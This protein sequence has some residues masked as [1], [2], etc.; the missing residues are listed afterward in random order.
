MTSDS[1]NI[2]VSSIVAPRLRQKLP[3]ISF[4]DGYEAVAAVCRTASVGSLITEVSIAIMRL[5]VFVAVS[6]AV[7][8]SFGIDITVARTELNAGEQLNSS[9]VSYIYGVCYDLKYKYS[10]LLITSYAYMSSTGLQC[11]FLGKTKE[12]F[13]VSDM[14]AECMDKFFANSL[15]INDENDLLQI[16]SFFL[17][18]N[19]NS[20]EEA[21]QIL[22]I[23]NDLNGQNTSH[24][25]QLNSSAECISIETNALREYNI[26]NCPQVPLQKYL[27]H[28]V[29][30]VDEKGLNYCI[31]PV[32][33]S[34]VFSTDVGEED[35][36]KVTTGQVTYEEA[37]NHCIKK[38]G[39]RLID[40][41]SAAK[42]FLLHDILFYPFM[43]EPK[44]VLNSYQM[45][46]FLIRSK[47]KFD[48]RMRM[49]KDAL[50]EKYMFQR[51]EYDGYISDE[52]FLLKRLDELRI[53]TIMAENCSRYSAFICEAS[54]PN[55]PPQK[56]DVSRNKFETFNEAETFC[57]REFKGH[58]LSVSSK[59][60]AELL[61][62]ILFDDMKSRSS[63]SSGRLLGIRSLYG[64]LPKHTDKTDTN[65]VITT[66]YGD[67]HSVDA[68]GKCFIFV[69]LYDQQRDTI[70]RYNCDR[71]RPIKNLACKVL[72]ESD[73]LD[74]EA[75]LVDDI[76]G[77]RKR[78]S[79]QVRICIVHNDYVSIKV[80]AFFEFA[81]CSI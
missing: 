15:S 51:P 10:D 50:R 38:F 80:K 60:E 71:T 20:S 21:S 9:S 76:G 79:L 22:M 41:N 18:H 1:I 57:R 46:S 61:Y 55:G 12:E 52:C 2:C 29:M 72:Q 56:Q 16:E 77:R 27:V 3:R 63:G 8:F 26:R 64:E 24:I 67:K 66:A 54:V 78:E 13:E 19:Y 36:V 5:L 53:D 74:A 70:L 4:A 30:A 62:E 81:I 68:F 33:S 75:L 28:P 40:V 35:N 32:G 39:G 69:R 42:N 59:N 34:S 31:F 17:S 47:I 73:D 11:L 58:L 7:S 25:S 45:T 48:S 14:N 43:S 23:S 49:Q 44:A 6:L 65:Y 37:E